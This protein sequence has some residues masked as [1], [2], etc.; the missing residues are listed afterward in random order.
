MSHTDDWFHYNEEH[1][2]LICIPCGVVVMPGHGGGVK[3]HLE[4]SH[5]GKSKNFPLSR[6]ER[7]ELFELHRERTLNPSPRMPD[8]ETRP[9]THLPVWDGFHCLKCHYV[10]AALSTIQ[11]HL[12]YLPI[13]EPLDYTFLCGVAPPWGRNFVRGRLRPQIACN[14]GSCV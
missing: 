7:G 2:I 6:K 12:I 4:V 10:C 8:S 11:H 14:P 5:K 3:G 13:I 1:D 9:I